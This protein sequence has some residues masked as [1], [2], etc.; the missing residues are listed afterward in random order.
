MLEFSES[1]VNS[2]LRAILLL[3][4]YALP[5]KG[6][7]SKKDR[8][9]QYCPAIDVKSS[10]NSYAAIRPSIIVPRH[11]R[12]SMKRIFAITL[13]AAVCAVSA[14]AQKSKPSGC[15]SGTAP[16]GN[17]NWWVGPGGLDQTFDFDGITATDFSASSSDPVEEIVV[18][19]DGKIITA[20][21]GNNPNGISGSDFWIVRYNSDGSLD[22]TFGDL[23]IST[24]QRRGYS[25][26]TMTNGSDWAR[27]LALLADGSIIV[28]GFSNAMAGVAKLDPEGD[29]DPSFGNGGKVVLNLG[30]LT[31]EDLAVQADGKIVIAGGDESFAI[32]RLNADGSLDTTFGS[33][34][35]RIVNPS[36]ASRGRGLSNSLAIQEVPAGSGDQRF[37]VGGRVQDS[38]TGTSRFMVMRFTATG[39]ID[40][41]FGSSG[42]VST[43]FAAKG[44]Q[45]FDLTVDRSNRIVAVGQAG[46]ACASSGE[47]GVARYTQNGQLDLSFSGDGKH[48]FSAYDAREWARAVSIDAADNIVIA[49]DARSADGTMNDLMVARLL[50]DGTPDPLFGPGSLG[51]GVVA[52]GVGATDIGLTMVLQPDGKMLVAGPVANTSSG[53]V[54]YLP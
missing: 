6:E 52:T 3:N 2:F 27:G 4:Q 34:G 32:G 35:T 17:T 15:P 1:K 45:I 47:A 5:F 9:S 26:V 43:S 49:G 13:V 24:A 53:V 14:I 29:L 41:S 23:D 31:I 8:L 7:I 33:G 12:R 21:H 44:D 37:V 25:I 48:N 19:P 18:Q 30:D 39:A 46:Q 22:T 28:G 42:R 20:G 36:T 40:T 51:P 38:S 11:L 10:Q 54:R 16:T 50:N